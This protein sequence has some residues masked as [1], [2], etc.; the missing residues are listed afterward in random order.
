VAWAARE[1]LAHERYLSGGFVKCFAYEC[2]V[3]E[4]FVRIAWPVSA[5]SVTVIALSAD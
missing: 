3:Y 1:R 5:M 4:C 2:F